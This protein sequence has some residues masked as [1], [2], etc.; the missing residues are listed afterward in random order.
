MDVTPKVAQLC[1]R[2]AVLSADLQKQ[3]DALNKRIGFD[4]AQCIVLDPAL[5]NIVDKKKDKERHLKR[6]KVQL[7]DIIDS[8]IE[9][10][11][12]D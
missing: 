12:L 4:E 2:L 10:E 3:L 8:S 6:W 9:F 1:F 7:K 11:R 5:Q